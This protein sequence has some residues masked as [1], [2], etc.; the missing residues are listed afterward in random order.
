MAAL[1]PVCKSL[2][3]TSCLGCANEDDV[4]QGESKRLGMNRRCRPLST[5]PIHALNAICP[6]FTMFPLEFPLHILERRARGAELVF[7]PFVGRGTTLY[8][9]RQRGV[10][11]IGMDS[12]PVAVAIA[13]AKLAAISISEA[14][15][16]AR[17]ILEA[18]S[19]VVP[20]NGAFWERAFH[21]AT[22]T[23]ICRL[24]EGLINAEE[25]NA[26]VVLRATILGILHG[27]QSKVGSYLSNQMQRTFAPKPDYAVRFWRERG[28]EPSRVDV[29]KA[30]ERKLQRIAAGKYV[31]S[32]VGWRD[33]H[34]GDA[35]RSGCYGVVPSGVDT[36]IT[37]PPYY[38]MRTYVADQWLRYWFIGGPAHVEY[39][40]ADDLSSSSKAE[41]CEG[42]GKTWA[43]LVE[44]GSDGMRMFIRFGSIPS[45][46]VDARQ[47]LLQSLEAS[48][49]R[50]KIVSI[51]NAGNAGAG[52]RQVEQMRGSTKAVDELDIHARLE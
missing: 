38:G 34:L 26:V 25:S 31:T 37:S 47:L 39:A 8:A 42:L 18:E 48:G 20:P 28:L 40:I 3:L 17:G 22:L 13:R 43:N 49:S 23:E 4:D 2:P 11:A 45:R 16:L 27:P 36:V 9:A 35:S 33:V 32:K 15:G 29:I 21:P 51:R 30:I 19:Q 14:I 24:R 46:L 50:W 12:S 44:C 7:D 52:K 1:G 41:F 6:Y 10:R 5:R